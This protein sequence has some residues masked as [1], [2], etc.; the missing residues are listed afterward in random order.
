[1][2]SL[3]QFIEARLQEREEA[4][5]TAAGETH[6]EWTA[7][8]PYVVKPDGRLVAGGPVHLRGSI[9]MPHI[10][11]HDPAAVLRD[12][13]ATRRILRIHT[14]FVVRYP[15][16]AAEPIHRDDRHC[17]GCGFTNMEEYAVRDINDCPTLRAIATRWS[18]HPDYRPE[19]LTAPDDED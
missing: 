9:V 15:E 10:A 2:E 18:D 6:T 5:L 17:L 1:M 16:H 7:F 19:W 13:E 11:L 14:V 12:V 3:I 4:A 8:G